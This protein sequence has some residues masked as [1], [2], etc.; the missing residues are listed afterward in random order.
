M[1]KVSWKSNGVSSVMPAISPVYIFKGDEKYLKKEAIEKLKTALLEKGSEA[2]N[3]NTYEMDRCDAKDILDALR[4]APIISAKR[5]IVISSFVSASE[6]E[7]SLIAEYAK[8]PSKNSCLVID[9]SMEELQGDFYASIRAYAKEMA[10]IPPKGDR[11]VSWIQAE[12]KKRAKPIRYEAAAMLAEIKEEDMGG[13]INEIEKLVAYA[14]KE[15]LVTKDHVEKLT[16]VSLMR[17]VFDLVDALSMKDAKRSLLI[18]NELLKARKAVPEILGLIGW[19]L[20]KVKRVK[21]ARV[22]TKKEIDKSLECLLEADYGIKTGH[23]KPQDA[24][25]MLIIKICSGNTANLI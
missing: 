22:F 10:F 14:G 21:D 11:L 2:F 4:S 12:F 18:S 24:L 19:R 6:K 1:D 20:R 17:S 7:K 13:L 9:L 16:G 25:E 23:L 15:P 5:L 3:F 8:N